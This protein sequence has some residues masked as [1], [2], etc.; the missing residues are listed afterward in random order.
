MCE[1]TA[2]HGR[3]T[4]WARHA[5][6]ESAFK[7]LPQVWRT[8]GTQACFLGMWHLLLF[9]SI[10]FF[11]FPEQPLYIVKNVSIYKHI[12]LR[13]DWIW[14]TVTVSW[15]R[16]TI[17]IQWRLNIIWVPAWGYLVNGW[18]SDIAPPPKKIQSSFKQVI[19]TAPVTSKFSSWLHSSRSPSEIKC[20]KK[21]SV[22]LMIVM[23]SSGAQRLFDHPV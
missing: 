3:G 20:D 9:H 10:F 5:M 19:V 11:L 22:Q 1:L 18:I 16:E 23:K 2:R 14:I 6:C 15:N 17:N 12:W 21:V 7:G 4:A 13:W 8:H